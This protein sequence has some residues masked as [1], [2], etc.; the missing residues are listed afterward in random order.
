MLMLIDVSLQKNLIVFML[1]D[2]LMQI[3]KKIFYFALSK[4]LIVLSQTKFAL[5]K[6]LKYFIFL[7]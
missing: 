2:F 3:Q 7:N 5:R 1:I 4:R 6:F